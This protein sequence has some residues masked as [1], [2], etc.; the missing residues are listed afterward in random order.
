M[1]TEERTRKEITTRFKEHRLKITIQSNLQ[2]VDYLEITLNLTNRLFQPYRK[3][4]NEPLSSTQ[5]LTTHPQSPS[6]YP[7][8]LIADYQLYYPTKKHSTKP[9]LSTKKPSNQVDST[10]AFA[11]ARRTQ[12]HPQKQIEIET[13]SGLTR[14]T[15]KMYE[16]TL[17]KPSSP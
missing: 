1:D 11:T 13:S 14:H 17:P 5:N 9:S 6:K 10:K 16:P 7:Q 3:P 2:S 8:P 12:S 4:N 15:A